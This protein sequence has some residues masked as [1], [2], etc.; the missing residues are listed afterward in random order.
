MYRI[1]GDIQFDKKTHIFIDF[2][3]YLLIW[4]NGENALIY[5]I[6]F[7]YTLIS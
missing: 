6:V 1:W 4:G 7:T 5:L 2:N 3:A